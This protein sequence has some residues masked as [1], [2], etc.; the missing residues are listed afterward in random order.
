MTTCDCQLLIPLVSQDGRTE[1][2]GEQRRKSAVL[3]RPQ[4]VSHLVNLTTGD[5]KVVNSRELTTLSKK[6]E[7][8]K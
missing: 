3:A 8:K 1:G 2:G 5:V 6:K 7:T 4:S